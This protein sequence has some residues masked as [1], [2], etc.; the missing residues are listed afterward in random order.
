[1][2]GST[3]SPPVTPIPEPATWAS[4]LCGLALLVFVTWRQRR[5]AAAGTPKCATQKRS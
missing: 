5:G 2:P 4:L 1:V 3:A